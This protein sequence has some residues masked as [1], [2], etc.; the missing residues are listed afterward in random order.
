MENYFVGGTILLELVC[1]CCRIRILVR[2]LQVLGLTIAALEA[3][4]ILR[5]LG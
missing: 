5:V 4:S 3:V 1:R 2:V